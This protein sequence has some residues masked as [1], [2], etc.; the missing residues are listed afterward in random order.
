MLSIFLSIMLFVVLR[1]DWMGE[2]LEPHIRGT[3]MASFMAYIRSNP[4][5]MTNMIVT[6]ICISYFL[7]CRKFYRPEKYPIYVGDVD[8]LFDDMNT[9]VDF[10]REI[11]AENDNSQQQA[12]TLGTLAL[13]YGGGILL[14]VLI[15]NPLSGR[16]AILS[17]SVLMLAVGTA[18]VMAGRRLDTSGSHKAE[19]PLLS[20]LDSFFRDRT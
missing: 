18:L 15:P 5:F 7:F 1:S 14:L 10:E 8:R 4:F 13:V 6:P 11:G 20:K 16:L 17:C 2:L 12:K 9:P 3:F 19:G